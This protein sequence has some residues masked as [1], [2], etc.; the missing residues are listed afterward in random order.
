LGDDWLVDAT[1]IE[2]AV[3]NGEVTLSGTVDRREQRRRA[4]DVAE[5]VSGVKHV[6]NNIRVSGT[7]TAGF[8]NEPGTTSSSSGASS[9]TYGSTAT[10][11]K[12]GS[13]T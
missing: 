2:V 7:T 4:E 10:S 9:G 1:E 11:R 12:T 5:S 6:Q 8:G 3:L 13:S